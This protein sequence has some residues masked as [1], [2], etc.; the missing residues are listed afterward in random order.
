MAF[1]FVSVVPA[2]RFV[3]PSLLRGGD[4]CDKSLFYGRA[5]DTF[6]L[7]EHVFIADMCAI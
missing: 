3:S 2:L 6:L 7:K 5:G 1:M 4:C